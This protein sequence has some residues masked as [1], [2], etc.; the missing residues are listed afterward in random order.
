MG[1]LIFIRSFKTDTCVMWRS[2]RHYVAFGIWIGPH[3]QYQTYSLKNS[4]EAGNQ[5]TLICWLL[6][7]YA[8]DFDSEGSSGISALCWSIW[9]Q[10]WL[11]LEFKKKFD[12]FLFVPPICKLQVRCAGIGYQNFSLKFCIYHFFRDPHR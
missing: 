12:F 4:H 2:D 6:V 5:K 3:L 9:V 11:C 10:S 8:M 7:S 1:I